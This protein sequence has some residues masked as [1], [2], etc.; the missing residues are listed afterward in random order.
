MGA[1][2][3]ELD[4]QQSRDGQIIVI[5]DTNF[6]R[7]TGVDANTWELDYEEIAK[8]DAGSFFDAAYAGERIPLRR[9]L[10]LQKKTESS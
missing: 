10:Y 1:D 3:I 8:L 2:W 6:R 4:V 7:T 5:H 9:W